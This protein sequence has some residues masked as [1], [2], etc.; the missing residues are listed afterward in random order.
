[1]QELR[2]DFDAA[3]RHRRLN[4]A[5]AKTAKAISA[6]PAPTGRPAIRLPLGTPAM[7]LLEFRKR[8]VTEYAQQAFR[9][10]AP[11]GTKFTVGFA[12]ATTEVD[13]TI[14]LGRNYEVTAAHTGAGARA[15]TC[16]GFACLP[17]GASAS[18]AKGSRCWTA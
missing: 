11:G 16:T 6:L 17:T 13:Y 3:R 7:R 12:G 10:G 15:L 14:D 2:D 8:T 4:Q 1:M 9:H 5:N 18:N